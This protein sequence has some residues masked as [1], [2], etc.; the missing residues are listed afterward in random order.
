MH[1]VKENCW[2][3]LV[4]ADDGCLCKEYQHLKAL[5]LPAYDDFCWLQQAIIC[6]EAGS[7]VKLVFWWRKG[8]FKWYTCDGIKITIST[9]ANDPMR[10]YVQATWHSLQHLRDAEARAE[11]EYASIEVD[12]FVRKHNEGQYDEMFTVPAP[13]VYD[14]D[15]LL[16]LETITSGSA[17][18]GCI[19]AA[20]TRGKLV[21][22]WTYEESSPVFPRPMFWGST[23]RLASQRGWEAI[24]NNRFRALGSEN[25]TPFMFTW[26]NVGPDV[27]ENLQLED[28][29]LNAAQ[30]KEIPDPEQHDCRSTDTPSTSEDSENDS[31]EKD[32]SYRPSRDNGSRAAARTKSVE[33]S[34]SRHSDSRYAVETVPVPAG[35]RA[36]ATVLKLNM[37]RKRS[38]QDDT[39]GECPVVK[40]EDSQSAPVVKIESLKP[41][42]SGTKKTP[43]DLTDSTV[44]T[45]A[46]LTAT[47]SLPSS[48]KSPAPI[49]APTSTPSGGFANST[50]IDVA[51]SDAA[52]EK[53]KRVALK[54]M[55]VLRQRDAELELSKAEL[56]YEEAS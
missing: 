16:G 38:V 11:D 52:R 47:Q 4:R 14:L 7:K 50:A 24:P 33:Q 23:F 5:P 13:N 40:T 54:K 18:A 1:D 27:V 46:G 2:M 49:L 48:A 12:C 25:G 3:E 17:A 39:A 37:K 44:A 6:V 22:N 34:R 29:M 28:W 36:P 56:E 45:S 35:V 26:T 8:H 43:F 19:F 51:L 9:R 21:G 41:E 10:K 55:E 20:V 30:H 32:N 53:A 42:A 31:S 15:Q